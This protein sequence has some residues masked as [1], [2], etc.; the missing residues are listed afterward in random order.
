MTYD[1]NLTFPTSAIA[2]LSAEKPGIFQGYIIGQA[3]HCWVAVADSMFVEFLR[4]LLVH[5][6]RKMYD[7]K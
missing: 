1:K 3:A 6:G 2:S 5:R 7:L 4:G